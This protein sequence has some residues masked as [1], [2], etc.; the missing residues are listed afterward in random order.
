MSLGHDWPRTDTPTTWQTRGSCKDHP[1]LNWF[2][3]RGQNITKQ[4]QV[5]AGCPVRIDCLAE[6]LNIGA[7]NDFGVWGGTGEHERR[8]MRRARMRCDGDRLVTTEPCPRCLGRG[9]YEGDTCRT[10]SGRGEIVRPPR[11]ANA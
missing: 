9:E 1:E 10:C 11:S 4:R 5:C 3:V 6:A 7:H 8:D 2:P